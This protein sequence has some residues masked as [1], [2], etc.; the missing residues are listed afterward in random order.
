MPNKDG[1]ESPPMSIA[2]PVADLP[3]SQASIMPRPS[4][5]HHEGLGETD[6]NFSI[7][8]HLS[9]LAGLLTPITLPL[10]LAP[11]I[12]WLV[13]R[14]HSVFVDDHGREAVNFGISFILLHIILGITI[15]GIFLIPVLWVIGIV[16][17]IRG[18]IAAS[19]SEYFR[20]P[21]TIRFIN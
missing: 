8:I 5:L 17:V 1:E 20:Y 15:V 13:R 16:N 2:S 21:M 14:Q 19:R 4:R 11:L 10:V 3:A 7:A 12:L 9:P 18:A 6:R